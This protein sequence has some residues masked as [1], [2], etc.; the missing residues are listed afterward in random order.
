MMLI[1]RAGGSMVL[2]NQV[3]GRK[4][5]CGI[6][7]AASCRLQDADITAATSTIINAPVRIQGGG[8]C[9][10]R[11]DPRVKPRQAAITNRNCQASGL[12]YHSR[13]SGKPGT[14]QLK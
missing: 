10:S 12:K 6:R 11:P 3:S 9:G 2:S 13:P 8:T 4:M 14:F 5:T 7:G 1:R